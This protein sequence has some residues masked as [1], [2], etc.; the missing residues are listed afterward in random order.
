MKTGFVLGASALLTLGGLAAQQHFDGKTLWRHVE[1]LAADDMEGRA[2]GSAGFDRAE[3]Y[4]VN[5][6]KRIDLAPGGTTGYFQPVKLLRRRVIDSDSSAA[7]I[8]GSEVVPMVLGEDA[9]FPNDVDVAPKIEASLVFLGYG[10]QI[11]EKH[12]NDFAGLDLKGKIAV[13]VPGTPEGIE[14]ALAARYSAASRRWKQ[15]TAAGVVGWIEIAAPGASWSFL[16]DAITTSTLYLSGDEFND[17]TGQKIHMVF[18][19]AHADKLFD[20]TG[21]T[22]AEV[23][24]L[25][26][27]YKPLPRFPLRVRLRATMRV[28]R[29][30]IDS[31]NV[32]AKLEGSDAQLRNEYVILSA[33]IDHLGIREPVNGDRIY[34]GAVDNASGVAALLDIAAALKREGATPRRSVLLTFFTAEEG[35][36]LGSRYFTEHPT[37]ERRSIVA[38]LNIDGIQAIVP[39][40]AVQVLGAEESDLGDAARRVAALFHV[41]VETGLDY[42]SS[43]FANSSDQGSF[44]FAGIPAVKLNVGFPGDLNTAQQKWR[45]ERYHTPFDDA[46][47][48]IDLETFATFEEIARALLLDVVNNPARPAWKPG[49]IYKSYAK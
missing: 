32:V 14:P 34:N 27:A 20:G 2:P 45:R 30:S 9:F 4:V 22:A 12:Y 16:R 26:K 3:A 36:K 47:Q 17:A 8:R 11:P 37:V 7:L 5:E 48:P 24:A 21:H 41:D 25:G 46:R 10:L 39:L 40:K 23:F 49:S 42:E 1:V 29:A 6:L 31:R 43:R 38:D 28:Q 15:F 13:T 19:P 33:H 44:A 18:N 35:G